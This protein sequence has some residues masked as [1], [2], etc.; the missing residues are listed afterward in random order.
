MVYRCLE[1]A[2]IRGIGNSMLLTYE[3]ISKRPKLRRKIGG[4]SVF[5]VHYD[6]TT[7]SYFLGIGELTSCKV[8]WMPDWQRY[9][10][11]K[12]EDD[13]APTDFE[14]ARTLLAAFASLPPDRF[15]IVGYTHANAYIPETV[16]LKALAQT[17][18]FF[19]RSATGLFVP[20]RVYA[21]RREP[22]STECRFT[23]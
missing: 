20:K 3:A 6:F 23:S 21:E 2:L 11:K 19:V 18:T 17:E 1:Y 8:K 14:T 15:A 16:R 10:S 13:L 7:R 4:K 22:L 9:L 5:W 12:L